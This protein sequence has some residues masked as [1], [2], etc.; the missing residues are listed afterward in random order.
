MSRLE[1]ILSAALT[2]SVLLN[3]GLFVYART[4]VSKLIIISN[5]IFDLGRMVDNFTQHT[6]VSYT[7]LTLPTSG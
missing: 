2:L 7:H 4:V 6:A 3:I 5:E 1:L